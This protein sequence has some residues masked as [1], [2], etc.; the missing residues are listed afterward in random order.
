MTWGLRLE[1]VRTAPYT[2]PG[3]LMSNARGPGKLNRRL[4][5]DLILARN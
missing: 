2:F 1:H 5:V 3:P 4:R